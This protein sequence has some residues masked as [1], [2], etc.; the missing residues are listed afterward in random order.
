M[1]ITRIKESM[2]IY[3]GDQPRHF[4]VKVLHFGNHLSLHYQEIKQNNGHRF[5]ETLHFDSKLTWLVVQKILSISVAVK[6]NL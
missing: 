3:S 5:F 2:N 6:F 4:G 1:Q